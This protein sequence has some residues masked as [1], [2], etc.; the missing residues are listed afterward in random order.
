MFPEDPAPFRSVEDESV[1]WAR[2]AFLFFL[3]NFGNIGSFQRY[4]DREGGVGEGSG[5]GSVDVEIGRRPRGR[6]S[7]GSWVRAV[8]MGIEEGS[9]KGEKE[10][11]QG[12]RGSNL[13]RGEVGTPG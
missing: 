9:A 1:G 5:S 7:G 6:G 10:S 2:G 4:P 11:C 13:R 12:D 8:E 3:D